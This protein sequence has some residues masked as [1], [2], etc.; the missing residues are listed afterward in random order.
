MFLMALVYLIFMNLLSGTKL[1]YHAYT[2]GLFLDKL[3]QKIDPKGRDTASIFKEYIADP[4]SEYTH[5]TTS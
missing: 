1:G 5:I 4:F 2:F 3:L